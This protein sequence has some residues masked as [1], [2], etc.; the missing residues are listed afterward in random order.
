MLFRRVFVIGCLLVLALSFQG[1]PARTVHAVSQSASTVFISP[2]GTCCHVQNDLFSV[3][4]ILNLAQGEQING[5]DIRINYT[6]AYTAGNHGAL[7][8]GSVN[9]NGGI[10][11]TSP[12]VL[13]DCIDDI[14]QQGSNGCPSDD[15]PNPG[16]IHLTLSMLG[17]A[18]SAG[19]LLF[20]IGFQVQNNTAPTSVLTIDRANVVNPYGDPSNPSLIDPVF[21]PVIKQDAIFGNSGA[22]AFFNYQSA[23][24]SVTPAILPNQQVNFNASSS[25]VGYDN[26]I[27]IKQFTWDFGDGQ[28]GTGAT[29]YHTFA[30]PKNYTVTLT[31]VDNR[32]EIGVI[33]RVV[34]VVFA[35]GNIELTVRNQQGSAITINVGVHLFNT[36]SSSTPFAKRVVSAGGNVRFN[37]LVPGGY[38]LTFSASGFD[39]MSKTETVKPGLTTMDTVYL[40]Q[41][42]QPADYS[43]LIYVGS[44]LGA[45]GAVTVA[46]VYTRRSAARKATRRSA[47]SVS[48]RTSRRF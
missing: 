10:L 16:Q 26:T 11:G 12:S 42:P 33:S 4:V 24:T 14:P 48:G 34:D 6:H 3:Y 28:T 21:I 18:L 47:R 30:L 5:F 1:W 40:N 36:S 8:A 20:S 39:N 35:L 15:S 27:G 37:S 41:T 31:I 7:R 43:G 29:P 17:G 32:N 13:V 2:T 45:L 44:I 46:I 9:Y 23:D 38:Y 25:F 19:G 22:V